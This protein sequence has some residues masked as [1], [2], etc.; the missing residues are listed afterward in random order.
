MKRTL[1]IGCLSLATA[2]GGGAIAA[3]PASAVTAQSCA[4]LTGSAV[5]SPGLTTTQANNTAS[6]TGTLTTCTPVAATGGSGGVTARLNIPNG[7]CQKLAAGGQRLY[8]TAT[9]R[10]HNGRAS[11]LS[12][13]FTTGTGANATLA[14]IT[15]KVASGLFV[16]KR[17]YGQIRFTVR[18]GQNCSPGHPIR[19]VTFTNTRAFTIFT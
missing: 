15:G 17:I 12:L 9:V 18:T 16:G 2:L 19:N 13:V 3:S 4:H 5:I 6:A 1:A 10:W 11:N 8:G 14:T 7:S